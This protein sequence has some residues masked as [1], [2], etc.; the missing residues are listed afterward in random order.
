ML[1][2][3]TVPQHV[4][5]ARL[6]NVPEPHSDERTVFAQVPQIGVCG[7][8][9]EIL[10]GAHGWAP[11]GRERLVTAFVRKPDDVKVVIDF[12]S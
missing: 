8:D 3:T 2:I 11:T 7:T 4:A 10:D 5:S 9:H 6:D 1:A 12:T